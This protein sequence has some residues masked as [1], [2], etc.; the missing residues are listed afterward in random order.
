M[1]GGGGGKQ[2]KEEVT[3]K[4]DGR[5]TER[6]EYKETVLKNNQD[7]ANLKTMI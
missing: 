3:V 7:L 6:S 2:G 5:N 4:E 1:K